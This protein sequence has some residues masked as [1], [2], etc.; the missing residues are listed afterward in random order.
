[1]I[2][3]QEIHLS[4]EF[5]C[6]YHGRSTFIGFLKH[7]YNRGQFFI[8]GFLRPGTRFYLPLLGVLV[9]SVVAV[10]LL[11]AY[12]LTALVWL[13]ASLGVFILGLFFGAIFF[14]VIVADAFALA[15]LGVPFAVV[16][17]AGLWRGVARKIVR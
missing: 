2:E 4:P 15:A 7:A 1:M 5:S 8:D 6:L 9:L 14:G 16:Y 13:G 10:G 17:L 3:R 11:L 12:P